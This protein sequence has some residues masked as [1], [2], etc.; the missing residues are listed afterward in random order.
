MADSALPTTSPLPPAPL[1]RGIAR[2]WAGAVA[3]LALA[4]V[5]MQY[6]THVGALMERGLSAFAAAGRAFSIQLL[7][8]TIITNT[9]VGLALGLVALGRWPGG[10]RPGPRTLTTL[11]VSLALVG[12]VYATLL[13]GTWNPQG[14]AKVA[15]VVLHYV[16]PPALAAWWVVYVARAGV[17]RAL[18]WQDAALFMLYPLAYAVYALLRGSIEGRYPY[19]FLHVDRLGWGR[20]LLTVAVLALAVW[21]AG[22]G[23]VWL[24]RRVLPAASPALPSR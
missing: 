16:T 22:L 14:W 4:G 21:A 3:I 23:A 1:Q 8:F 18:R 19:P 2:A 12:V 9:L 13:R 7:F 15:D 6:A 11:C 10:A 20:V 17:A 5:G 24:V